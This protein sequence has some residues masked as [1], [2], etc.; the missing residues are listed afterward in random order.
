VQGLSKEARDLKMSVEEFQ[1]L[2]DSC[3]SLCGWCSRQWRRLMR[4]IMS[5]FSEDREIVQDLF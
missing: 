3:G 1:E 2:P 5:Y 4:E